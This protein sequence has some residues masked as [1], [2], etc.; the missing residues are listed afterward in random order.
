MKNRENIESVVYSREATPDQLEILAD[1]PWARI[2]KVDPDKILEALKAQR[3]G[4]LDDAGIELLWRLGYS[5]E[6]KRMS[7]SFS[8][9]SVEYSDEKAIAAT[10]AAWERDYA[11]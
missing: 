10:E 7:A 6:A 3:A 8:A 1:S 5:E 11:D 4:K 2:K 9:G